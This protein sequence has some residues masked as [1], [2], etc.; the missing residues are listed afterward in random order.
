MYI[1]LPIGVFV[2]KILSISLNNGSE[3]G[4]LTDMPESAIVGEI[5]DGSNEWALFEG[6]SDAGLTPERVPVYVLRHMIASF[7]IKP[8]VSEKVALPRPKVIQ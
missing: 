2:P 1:W 6:R 5:V 7:M 4:I 8:Y 3:V